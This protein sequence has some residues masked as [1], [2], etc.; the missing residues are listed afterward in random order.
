MLNIFVMTN[1]LGVIVCLLSRVALLAD[2]S[3]CLL[4]DTIDLKD[5]QIAG[6]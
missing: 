6:E 4:L 2:L 3:S 5:N 1:K